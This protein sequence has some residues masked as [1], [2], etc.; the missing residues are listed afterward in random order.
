M[1]KDVKPREIKRAA[2]IGAGTMG[3]GIAMCFA[4]A[5]IPVTIL[6]DQRRTR[7]KR[8]L[9][10]VAKNY[11][12]SVAARRPVRR[13]DRSPAS[14]CS[15]ARPIS[16]QLG[17][18]DIVI[19]AVFED[20]DVKQRG[21]RAISTGSPSPTRCSPPT[22]PISMSTRSRACTA[23]RG[24]VL[25]MHFFSPANVMRLLE[26]VR[27]ADTAPE[28][29]RDR[30]RSR[31]ARSARCRWWSGSATALSAT[32]CCARGR[33]RRNGCCSKAHCRRRST[34]R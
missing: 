4:N 19:E 25:G 18:A 12:T 14:L 24:S 26:I 17:E 31:H 33:P 30:D 8:G 5:G 6:R 10:T 21:L 7:S 29:A 13:R 32:A 15:P 20:M 27:G 9:D 2:V 3:G 23:R 16:R 34:A 28:R 1:P 11:Q 22:P